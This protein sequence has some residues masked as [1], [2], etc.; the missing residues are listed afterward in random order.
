MAKKARDII[1]QDVVEQKSDSLEGAYGGISGKKYVPFV[2]TQKALVEFTVRSLV[3]GAVLSVLFGVANTYLGLKVGLTVSASIPAAVLATGL[4]KL[5]F[6]SGNILERN[7]VQTVASSGESIAGGIMFTLPALFLWGMDMKVMTVV[8]ASVLG[9]LIGVLFFIPLR[10]YLTVEEHGKLIYPEGMACAEVLVSGE[11][12]GAG[13]GLVFAGIAVGGVYKFFSS[14]LMAWRESPEWKLPFLSNG[15]IGINALPSLLGVGFI[16][17][18]DVGKFML[19]GGL[20]A[21]L[22]IIPLISYF[23]QAVPTAIFPSD[24][25]IAQMDAW[26]IWSKYVRYI[27]AGAVAAGGFISLATSAPTIFKSFRAAMSGLASSQ[28][29]ESEK[30]TEKDLSLAIVLGGTLLVAA[31]ITFTPIVPGGVVGALSVL[32]FGFFFAAVSSRIVGIVGVSNNPVSGMTIATLLVLSAIVKGLGFSGETGM[33]VAIVLGSIV[34]VAIAVAGATAQNAKTT[35]ILGG[36]PKYAQVAQYVG[37]IASAYFV[38]AI[39]VMLHGAYTMG[40]ADLPAPQATLMSMVTKGVITGTLPWEFVI[41]GLVFGVAIYLMGLPILP[42]ALGL[43]LPVHLSMGILFGGVVR[44][45]VEKGIAAQDEL[46]DKV[47]RGVLISSG[48][49]AGDALI[50]ILI[51]FFAYIEYNIAFLK[52]TVL[53]ANNWFA[54]AMFLVVAWFTYWYTNRKDVQKDLNI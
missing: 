12:G 2:S 38:G 1:N 3:I 18:F 11:K 17:G 51:A 53:A 49:I 30:R 29:G 37:V 33:V 10:R 46:K 44:I 24:V 9:G 31:I 34:C 27:G 22:V 45:L 7:I 48:L 6:R 5:F 43:Y 32:F 26:A 23:G 4:Y 50:G 41:M 42:V 14:G 15:L 25:P 52:G 20:F 39:I 13:A 36:T 47:E 35:F 21:W 8:I 54:L 40:S 16:V 19:A 28:G